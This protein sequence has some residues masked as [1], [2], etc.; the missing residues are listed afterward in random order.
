[1]SIYA[2]PIFMATSEMTRE[3]ER[4]RES[5]REREGGDSEIDR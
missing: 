3:I 2:T 1:M 4:D 5:E